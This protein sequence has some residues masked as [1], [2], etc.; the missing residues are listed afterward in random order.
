MVSIPLTI[1]TCGHRDLAAGS[2]DVLAGRVRSAIEGWQ[3]QAP[4]TPIQVLSALA[5]GSD[6][7]VARAAVEAGAELI[8]PLPL[9]LE[10]Y[11]K[12]FHSASSLREFDAL[13]PR[14][15]SVYVVPGPALSRPECYAVL[16]THIVQRCDVL[17]A[18]WDGDPSDQPGGTA[19]V[20]RE[21]LETDDGPVLQI[22]TPRD[23]RPRPDSVFT[24]RMIDSELGRSFDATIHAIDQFNQE[25]GELAGEFA[26]DQ[27]ALPPGHEADDETVDGVRLFVAADALSRR[28]QSRSTEAL[29]VLLSLVFLAFVAY[30]VYDDHL[31]G[32]S[33]ALAAY[34]ACVA[35]AYGVY[36][37]AKRSRLQEQHLDYRA[38]AEALRVQHYWRIAGIPDAVSGHYRLQQHDELAWIANALRRFGVS[39]PTRIDCD[40]AVQFVCK[41]W[42]EQQRDYFSQAIERISERLERLEKW[43]DVLVGTGIVVAAATLAVRLFAP[44][45]FVE[46]WLDEHPLDALFAWVISLPPVLAAFLHTYAEKEAMAVVKKRY[47]R[48]HGVYSRALN[49][50]RKSIAAGNGAASRNVIHD[51]GLAALDQNADWLALRRDRPIEVPHPA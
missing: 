40:G 32:R 49:R 35:A 38:L 46:A 45:A 37:I 1:G 4:H 20:V 29:V 48:A 6:C 14:A 26:N 28:S 41:H 9:P 5:E 47:L 7:I 43:T 25:A 15:K 12:D 34:L 31:A 22:I 18:L 21:K 23:R 42:I 11:R 8:V 44:H 27:L 13:I 16:G 51:V 39:P 3:R 24:A 2:T 50:L 17:V 33:L 19:E 30:D 36:V 10:E